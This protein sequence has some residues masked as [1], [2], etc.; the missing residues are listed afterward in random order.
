MY[1]GRACLLITFLALGTSPL[2]GQTSGIT[3]STGG[4][5]LFA[6][7]GPDKDLDGKGVTAYVRATS[8]ISRSLAAGIDTW[9]TH[10]GKANAILDCFTPP[11]N[12]PYLGPTTV[13]SFAPMLEV[14][15]GRSSTHIRYRF[16]PTLNWFLQRKEASQAVGLGARAGITLRIGTTVPILV[17]L[18]VFGRLRGGDSPTW[19]APVTLGWEW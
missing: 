2:G 12:A 5:L 3:F 16:G 10:V 19:T 1:R 13:L 11:C 4:G 7:R 14:R 8:H 17:S 15:E 9:L 6:D 18:D